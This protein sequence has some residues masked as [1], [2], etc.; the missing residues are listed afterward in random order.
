MSVSTR[1]LHI[2]RVSENLG[3]VAALPALPL[4]SP[5]NSTCHSIHWDR[6][7]F[8]TQVSILPVCRSQYTVMQIH[9]MEIQYFLIR[10]IPTYSL[11][12]LRCRS[13]LST[14][15]MKISVLNNERTF[16]FHYHF[17][18]DSCRTSKNRAYLIIKGCAFLNISMYFL[19]VYLSLRA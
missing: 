12:F 16:F 14:R 8:H 4:I 10:Y 1:S 5:L 11:E 17:C 2:N 6:K 7:I 18:L 19:S 3:K 13:S 9:K 15:I